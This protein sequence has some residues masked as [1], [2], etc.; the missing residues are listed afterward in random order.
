M[1]TWLY[2]YDLY[3][4]VVPE[5]REMKLTLRPLGR[6]CAFDANA[7]YEVEVLPTSYRKMVQVSED[8]CLK[9]VPAY[10]EE[11]GCLTFSFTFEKE[12]EHFL[13]LKRDGKPVEKFSVY[14]LY[15]DLASRMPLLGDLHVHSIYSDGQ[16]APEI[17][18]ADYRRRGYDFMTMTDHHH[19]G[20]SLA[21]IRAYQDLNIDLNI[22]PGE[23]VHLPGNDIHIVNFGGRHSVNFQVLSNHRYAVETG[24]DPAHDAPETWCATPGTV[25]PAPVSEEEYR[26]QVAEILK[27]FP[28]LPAD[29]DTFSF[30]SCVWVCRRIREAGGLSIFAHPYWIKYA[31]HVPEDMNDLLFAACPFDAFEVLGGERYPQQNEAQTFLYERQMMRGYKLPV[32]GSSDSHNLYN[33][34]NSADACTIVFAPENT[35]DGLI[36]SVR[37]GWSVA[38]DLLV[39]DK[40][41]VGDLRLVRYARFLLEYYFPVTEELCF[42]EGRLMKAYVCGTDETA[43]EQL[44]RLH[45]RVARLRAHLIANV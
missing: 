39:P 12:Q 7:A 9:T 44:N 45:G 36:V 26:R 3:P 28:D 35:A 4:R 1:K 23:E 6:H 42:E 31:Y 18:A 34:M 24:T 37:E 10:P 13:F 38:V 25:M 15:P 16:Q 33:D 43:G 22:V 14:S 17:V 41:L 30:G 8:T 21:A 32:V 19:F 40:R 5:G 20:G 29:I 27:E 2:N 11:N